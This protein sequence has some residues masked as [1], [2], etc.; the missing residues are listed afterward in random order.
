VEHGTTSRPEY[1]R[2]QWDHCHIHHLHAVGLSYSGHPAVDGGTIGFPAHTASSLVSF[3]DAL[4]I[5][6]ANSCYRL[7]C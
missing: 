1:G 5:N 6:N 7:Y 3:Y 2:V 4:F